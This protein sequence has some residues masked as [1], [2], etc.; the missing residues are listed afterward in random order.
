ME[1]YKVVFCGTPEIG[2]QILKKLITVENVEV[3]LVVSQPDKPVGRK[4]EFLPTP[5]KKVALENNLKLI[6][7][8]KIGAE[9]ELIKSL[10]PDF[11][12]TCAFGQFIPN[13]ILALPK[14][15]PLNIHGSLLPKYR[16]GAPIQYAIWNG[17]T[18]TGVSI[19]RMVQQMDAGPYFAQKEVVIDPNDT[20]GDLFLKIGIAGA[21]LIVESLP[22]IATGELKPID[23]DEEA[24]TFSKNLTA[25]QEKIDWNQ[26]AEKIHNQ[27]RAFNPNPIAYTT[28]KNERYKIFTSRIV[29][30]QDVFVTTMKVHFPGEILYFDKEGIIV[31]TKDGMLKILTFQKQ[32]KTV[33]NAGIFA[34]SNLP[35]GGTF[36]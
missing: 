7:P 12:V 36:E 17:E 33:T 3:V 35:I 30:E 6:Q 14:I 29:T 19:M 31:Q 21:E 1:K 9:F 18:K 10:N 27:I 4:K 32:G 11:L 26:S 15:E 23:Q 20:S 28:L 8:A 16:G 22:L 2:A 34:L 25:D 13:K 5:V 24:V